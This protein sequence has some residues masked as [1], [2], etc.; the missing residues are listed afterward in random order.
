M[1]KRATTA[2]IVFAAFVLLALAAPA[3]AQSNSPEARAAAKELVETMRAVD[4]IKNLVPLFMQQLKPAIVQGRPEVERDY[5]AIIPSLL[6]AMNS[7]LSEFVDATAAIYAA[8]LTVDEMKQM[9]A[10]Y[11]TPVGQKFLEKMPVIMQQSL[12]MGQKFGEQLVGDL[13]TN[14]I[15]ELRKRGHN[16]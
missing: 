9:T 7:R 10:F 1:A 16:I 5:S 6:Q 12:A 4:Q 2:G 8:N 14:M 15:D 13:R 11:R 3:I